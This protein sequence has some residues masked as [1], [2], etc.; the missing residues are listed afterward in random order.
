[1]SL[2]YLEEQAF[3]DD[4]M[5]FE[6]FKEWMWEYIPEKTVSNKFMHNNEKLCD[7]ITFE[8]WQKYVK[9]NVD[10]VF[11]CSL[12]EDIF[13]NLFRYKPVLDNSE[14]ED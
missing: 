4:K 1:M 7:S 8:C 13:S 11:I 14:Y 5:S 6:K 12:V 3:E 9:G 10:T 2:E